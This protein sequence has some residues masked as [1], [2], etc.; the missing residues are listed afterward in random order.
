M[1][2]RTAGQLSVEVP[3]AVAEAC[4][5]GVV[6]A[7]RGVA[8]HVHAGHHSRRDALADGFERALRTWPTT[9]VPANP[10]VAGNC[11]FATGSADCS[12]PP[13]AR[14]AAPLDNR[15]AATLG[16]ARCR[17]GRDPRQATGDAVRVRAPAIDAEVRTPL[18]LQVVLGFDAERIARVF[19]CS[20]PRRRS[21][22]SAQSAA[23]A[24]PVSRFACRRARSP[25]TAARRARS[26]LRRIRDRLARPA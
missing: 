14:T 25:R 18:M 12:P 3:S 5:A 22:S 24:T 23:S 15:V 10:R 17:P 2:G 4:C 7:A 1:A 20:L 26:Y 8:R 19:A 13:A 21:V 6:W 11:G 16:R 9:G